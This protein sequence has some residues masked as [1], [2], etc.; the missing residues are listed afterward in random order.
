MNPCANK[1]CFVAR[2]RDGAELD[3]NVVPS[4]VTDWDQLEFSLTELPVLKVPFSHPLSEALSCLS[5][6]A[7]VMLCQKK[8]HELII[9]S[10]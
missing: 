4:R 1:V 2:E 10:N 5:F 7:M 8:P 3:A 9:S 6:K